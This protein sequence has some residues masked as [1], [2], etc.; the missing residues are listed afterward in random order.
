MDYVADAAQECGP[1]GCR[2]ACSMCSTKESKMTYK[3]NLG[4]PMNEPAPVS[5]VSAAAEIS[6]NQN[7]ATDNAKRKAEAEA[8]EAARVAEESTTTASSQAAAAAEASGQ[9]TGSAAA[10]AAAAVAAAAACVAAASAAVVYSSGK[11][12]F[13][14][15]GIFLAANCI[16]IVCSVVINNLSDKR[17]YPTSWP[18]INLLK[19]K[20]VS[21]KGKK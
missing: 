18:F 6:N 9:A 12:G 4:L 11:Y 16:A 19:A 13:V 21:P 14:D 7:D 2:Y 15:Y 5:S 10:S 20:L 3:G 17:Q 8:A 1:A